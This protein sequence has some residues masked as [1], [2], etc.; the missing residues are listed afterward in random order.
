[1]NII[2]IMIDTMR[3]DYIGAN[4]AT[5]V[6][7]PNIDRLAEHSWCFDRAFS[8][9]ICSPQSWGWPARNKE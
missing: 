7:T 6:D 8:P 4:G 2:F 5:Q 9:R 1:M 3:Y